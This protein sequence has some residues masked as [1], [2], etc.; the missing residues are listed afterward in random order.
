MAEERLAEDVCPDCDGTGVVA[1]GVCDTCGG[2]GW[3]PRP[4][5]EEE[6]QAG[7]SGD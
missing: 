7:D 6:I 2:T 5:P 1:D 3:I 4:P